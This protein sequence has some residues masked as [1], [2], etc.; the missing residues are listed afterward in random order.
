MAPMSSSTLRKT[1]RRSR[2]SVKSRKK[3]STMLSH[4]QPVGGRCEVHVEARMASKPPL[5]FGMLLGGV[6]IHDQ[7][8]LL[9]VRG[10]GINPRA[11]TSA[12]PDGFFRVNRFQDC[13]PLIPGA[14]AAPENT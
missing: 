1:P 12:T 14:S 6:V 11:G 2:F 10:H 3:R 5:D 8:N 7:V 13:N 4:E 9:V